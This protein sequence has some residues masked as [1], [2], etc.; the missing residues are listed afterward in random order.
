MDAAT[1]VSVIRHHH[2]HWCSLVDAA[3]V[4]LR[5][6]LLSDN[7]RRYQDACD[8]ARSVWAPDL[9][10]NEAMGATTGAAGE[11]AVPEGVW[12]PIEVHQP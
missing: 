11:Q 3:S 1:A 7:M 4:G 2:I 8:D 10:A 6:G 12:L 5:V 9:E